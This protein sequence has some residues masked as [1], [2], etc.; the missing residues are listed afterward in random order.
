MN[1]EPSTSQVSVANSVKIFIGYATGA[2]LLG[3]L[4]D[5]VFDRVRTTLDITVS[6]IFVGLLGV[7]SATLIRWHRKK[8][9]ART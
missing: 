3:W 6:A 2:L 7:A 8:R 1:T 9:I 5:I 4:A